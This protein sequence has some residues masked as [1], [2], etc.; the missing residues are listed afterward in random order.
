M[1]AFTGTGSL[2]R[3]ILRRDRIALPIWVLLLSLLAITLAASFDKLYPTPQALQAF[4]DET[5][6]SPAVIAMLGTVDSPTLG[7]L[8]AW[9]WSMAIA[10][11][12]GAASLLTVIR[13]TRTDEEQGRREL[14]GATVVGRQAPLTAALI[15]T[16]G[17]DL[18]VGLITTL[19]LIGYG[20]PLAGSLALGLAAAGAGWTF[21][22]VAGITAQLAERAATARGLAA[23]ALALA[24]LVKVIGDGSGRTAL[25]WLSPLGWMRKI[26]AYAAEQ[27]WIF[28]LF[29]VAFLALVVLAYVLSARR[30]LGAGLLPAR[31]GPASA[32]PGLSSPLAL[33]WRLQR[34]TLLAWMA[35]F[36][37]V[38]LIFGY[39]AQ[40]SAE[41]LA[42]NPQVL[43]YLTRS[44]VSLSDGFFTLALMIMS[45]VLAVYAISSTLQLRSEE[46]AGRADPL[47]AGPVS[48]RRWA[49][50]HLLVAILGTAA[51]VVTFGLVG[52]LTYGLSSGNIGGELPQI[53]A[54]ALAYLPA[55]WVI[56][57][58]TA[59]LFGLFPRLSVFASWGMLV[60][61]I[62]IDLGGELQLVG[63]GVLNLSPFTHVPK[64]L[65]GQGSWVPLLGLLGA[66]ALLVALGLAGFSRRDVG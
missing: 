40:I 21:A 6:G 5:N 3:L 63:Q 37:L 62:L 60:I 9:R 45:E 53:L 7:G 44:G 35:A 51:V 12:I 57:G 8:V 17:A 1:T 49:A 15:V 2:I 50:S 38:G 25:L 24:Y 10:I 55:Y 54:A 52:G 66:A 41:L 18:L 11:L 64:V 29:L 16:C 61:L 43:A 30:D 33:A 22:A 13:H 31:L 46:V 19:S 48:R 34:G 14:L 47:L 56:A 65:L 20:L 36:A 42:A 39:V 4:A 27:W 26:Q 23:A 32:A 58:L 59:A 28:G